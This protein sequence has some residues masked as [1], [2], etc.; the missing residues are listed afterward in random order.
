MWGEAFT[1][2]SLVDWWGGLLFVYVQS[3]V[4]Q[5]GLDLILPSC[6]CVVVPV[7]AADL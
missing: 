3:P 2:L 6:V 7:A 4:A 1:A 5:A